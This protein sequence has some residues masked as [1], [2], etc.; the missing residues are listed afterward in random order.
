MIG[1]LIDKSMSHD[2]P[3]FRPHERASE[4][5]KLAG[6]PTDVFDANAS[7]KPP[8]PIP[9]WFAA[10]RFVHFCRTV[11]GYRIQRRS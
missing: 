11:L 3:A 6:T 9:H 7:S 8:R 4:I 5:M 2:D 1:A 10:K